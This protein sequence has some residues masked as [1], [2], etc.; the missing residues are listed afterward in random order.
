[1]LRGKKTRFELFGDTMNYASRMESLCL[2][3][4]IQVSEQ[5]ADLLI[6]AGKES[7]LEPRRAMVV[8]KG[9][10]EVQTYWLRISRSSPSSNSSLE[11]PL[12]TI[13]DTN[14]FEDSKVPSIPI[15]LHANSA[16]SA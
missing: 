6:A 3:G 5:T 9:K 15:E 8:A 12:Q 1:M 16:R 4:K 11:S 2:P 13:S 10:G 14:E 7:W